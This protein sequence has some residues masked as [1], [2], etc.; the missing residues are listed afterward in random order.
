M[1]TTQDT[2]ELAEEEFSLPTI[3]I[4]EGNDLGRKR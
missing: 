3:A 2:F 4:D 1:F